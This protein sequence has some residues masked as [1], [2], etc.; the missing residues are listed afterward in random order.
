MKTAHI[1]LYSLLALLSAAYSALSAETNAVKLTQPPTNPGKYAAMAAESMYG[2]GR[3]SVSPFTGTTFAH[4]DPIDGR[5]FTGLG[6]GYHVVR[7]I[8]AAAEVALSDTDERFIDNFGAFG[9]GYLPVWRTGFALFG[10]L[11]WKRYIADDDTDFLSTGAGVAFRGKHGGIR[12]GGRRLDDIN[13]LGLWE[14][15]VA[16]EVSF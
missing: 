5:Q 7:N 2:A 4:A 15:L 3:F 12:L 8:E 11:G 10:E 9:R 14:V 1:L 13:G 16:A 6:V